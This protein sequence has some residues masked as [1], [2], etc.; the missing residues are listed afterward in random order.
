MDAVSESLHRCCALWL[1]CIQHSAEADVARA[2]IY[3]LW[4][5]RCRPVTG[6]VVVSAQIWAALD[7]LARRLACL[8]ADLQQR[9]SQWSGGRVVRIAGHVPVARPFPD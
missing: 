6:T 9:R 3:F 1:R 4:L 5:A 2:Q 8:N 7:H